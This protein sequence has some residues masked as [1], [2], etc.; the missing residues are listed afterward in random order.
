MATH[1]S[2]LA[3]VIPWTVAYQDLLSMESQESDTT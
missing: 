1:A 3:W 2:L